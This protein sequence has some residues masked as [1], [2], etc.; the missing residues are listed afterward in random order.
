MMLFDQDHNKSTSWIEALQK[1]EKPFTKEVLE[2]RQHESYSCIV[3]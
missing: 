1:G 2:Q 3:E